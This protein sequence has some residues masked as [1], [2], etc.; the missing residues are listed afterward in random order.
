M[1]LIKVS[2][3]F[4]FITGVALA[5]PPDQIEFF[6]SKIRPVL[7]EH[8][9][10]C[11]NSIKKQEG[12]LALDYRGALFAGGD[13]GEAVVPGK[14]VKS[15][16]ILAMQHE[17]DYEM[18]ANAPKLDDTVIQDFVKWVKLGAPDPRLTKPSQIN[19]ATALDWQLVRDQRL[20]WWSFQPL[21]FH[22]APPAKDPEWNTNAIDRFIYKRM[23]SEG[24]EPQELAV[25]EVLVR[26]LHHILIGLPPS[27]ETVQEF[28][29]NPT[30]HAYEQLVERLLASK[31]FG[32]RWARHWMDWYRYAESHGSEG[33]P[34]I[35]NIQHYRDYLIRA[36]NSDV[37]YNQ[38]LLE[39]V[40]G[41]L[42]ENP[43]INEELGINESAIGP[44]HF[45]MVPHGFGVTDAYD[46]QI[47]FTDN[48]IDVLT[49][50]MLGLTVSCAR[51]H[52]HKF[53]PISQKDFYR[54]YG[55][56]VS[57]RASSVLIDSQE[58]LV[59]NKAAI[60]ALKRDIRQSFAD[61]W[62]GQIGELPERLLASSLFDKIPNEKPQLPPDFEKLSEGE[63]KKARERVKTKQ[64]R[65]N[66]I[67]QD[68]AQFM[69]PCIHWLHGQVSRTPNRP[70]FLLS[71]IKRGLNCAV[72][73][74]QTPFPRT[75]QIS[76]WTCVNRQRLTNGI[77]AEMGSTQKLARRV[78]LRFELRA[79]R[80]LRA[81]IPQVFT[82]T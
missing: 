15:L 34:R 75:T 59:K 43:R 31:E 42:L 55:V 37:P 63:K 14:P 2:P 40:A 80:Y 70:I 58:K 32:E 19:T 11:H 46:E 3:L 61:Y 28:V 10:K 6:E 35:P 68:A 25:P 79:R 51:C 60:R 62:L 8:C 18:P 47:T 72:S 76:I 71:S 33:D 16:L 49:K 1:Q 36:L 21:Q 50:A 78:P 53:D 41:D 38:L 23:L 44:A 81:F 54:L 22:V 67:A 27:P 45:R 64:A 56:M 57:N 20:K 17:G 30:P 26:R 82:A 77:P 69:K 74:K 12:G 65:L 66:A 39:H 48:Q 9:Y 5:V 7:V 24:L 29:A 52:D 13:S 4:F 73:R